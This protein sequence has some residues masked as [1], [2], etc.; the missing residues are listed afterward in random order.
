MKKKRYKYENGTFVIKEQE[1]K[2]VPKDFTGVFE[3]ENGDIEW[4]KEGIFHRE[5]DPAVI[6]Y[7]S[8]YW[9]R[10]GN[11]HREDGPAV[12]RAK[13]MSGTKEWWIDGN[14]LTWKNLEKLNQNSSF[15][16]KEKGK[17]GLEWLTFLTEDGIEE[18]PILPG[19]E[20]ERNFIYLL[21]SFK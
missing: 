13:S 3:Y 17:Y 7:G 15:L 1:K 4:F 11:L 12:E 21:G 20:T 9:Y 18:F 8:K 10:E 14:N 6:E 16:K 2:D 19:M 5:G